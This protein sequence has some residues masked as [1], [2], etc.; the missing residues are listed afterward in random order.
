MNYAGIFNAAISLDGAGS[1]SPSDAHVDSFT[2]KPFIAKAQGH[3]PEGAFVV[4]DPNLIFNGEYKRAGSDLVL[5]H[6]GHEF[7]VP[8]Y[9]R[10]DK[11][12]ALSSPDGAHLSGDIVNA[13]TGHVQYA[14][15]ASGIAAA[16]V[17]GHVTKLSGSATAVRNGVSIILNNGDNVEKGDV[18]STGGDSTLGITFIDGTVFGL[19]SNARMVLNEMVYDPNGS[20]NSSLLSLV[21]GTITFVAGETAKHGDMKIDT[22]V[23][24]MGIRGTAVLSQIHFV[25][26]AGGG[27]PQPEASFQVLVEPNGTT[28]SYILF[29]KVTLLP[30]ATVNQAGQMI[31]ISGGNVSISNALMSPDVQK[32]ITDVFTLKFTDNNTNTKLTTNFTDSIT[33]TSYDILLKTP[34]GA[35]AIATFA[36]LNPQGPQ[37]PG[38][39]TSTSNRIPGPPDARTLDLNGNVTSE[40]ALTERANTTGDTTHSD[41]ISGLITF[42]DQNLGDRPTVSVS[43]G[44]AP[45]YVYKDAGLHDVTGSLTSLQKQDIAATLIN[46]DVVAKGGNTNT[47]SAV[48]TYTIPDHVFDFLAAGETLTL[49]YTVRIANNFTVSPDTA[50]RTITITITGTNDKPVITSSV[51][52]ITFEGGTSVAGGPLTSEVPTSGTLTFKDVDLT[53]THTVAVK[54]TS[55]TLPDGTVPPGPLALF[56]SAMSAAIAAGADSKGSG[57]GTINWSLAALPV[58]LADFIPKNEVLTLVYTVTLTDAQGATSQQTITITIT[59]TDAAAVVW[60]ATDKAGA[61]SGG[62]WKDAANW[63]TGTVPTIDDDVIVIT[64]Q[65]HGLTPSYPVTIDTAAYAKSITMNDFGGPPPEVINKS[66]LTISGALNMSADSIFTNSAAGVMSVGGK[67]E[68]LGASVLTNAGYLTLAGG[69]DFAKGTTITNSGMIE[70]SGGTLKTLALIHNAGG[71]LKADAGTT[72]IVDTAT[73]DGGTV[74]ILGTLELDGTSLIENGALNSSGAVNVKGTVEFAHETVSNSSSGTVKVLANGWL[75]ID[76]GSSVTNTGNVTVDASGK[77]IVNGATISGAGTVTNDGELD[78]NGNAILSGGV[79][80]N[81]AIFNVTGTGNALDGETVTNAGTIEVLA[82][83]VLAI[84][85]GSTVNNSSGSVIVGAT[86]ALTLDNA[87]ISGGAINGGGT[88]HL[89]GASKIDGGATLSVS[90]VTA[91]AKLTLDGVTVS[92]STITDNSSIE[93]DNTVKLKD[94]AKIQGGAITNNGTLEIAGAATLLNDVLT[95]TGHILKIGDNQTLALSGTEI[96]GGTLTVAGT[97]ASSGNT[98]ITDANISNGYLLESTLGGLLTLVATTPA[99]AITNSGIIQANGAKLDIDHEAVA[100]TGTLAAINAGTLK[101]ISATVTNTGSGAVSVESGSMLDLVGAII[102]GGTVTI[103]GTLESTGASAINDADITNTGIITVTGGA[104]TI[105]PGL[106]HAIIN[107][108]LIAAVTGGTLKLTTATITNTGA[109]ITVDGTSKLYLTDVS[110][111]GGSLSNAGNLYSVGLN[112]ITGSVTN[113]GTIEVQGGTLNLSGGL[114]GVGSLIIDDTATLEL[115]GA[116]A[117]TVTFA[118]GTDT[119]QLDNVA[120]QSFTGTIAG[121]STKGG[122]FTITGAADIASASGDALDFTASGGASATPA[123]IVLTPTGALTGAANGIVVTQN[124]AGAISLTATKDI[125]GLNGNGITLRDS[126]TGVGGITVNSLTGKAT[127]TGA[128]SVGVLVENLNAANNG[129]ISITQLGGAVG[130]AYGIDAHTEG[131]G[132]ISI[133]IGGAITGSSTYGI[134]SRSY[135]AGDQTVTTEAGSVVTSGSSGIV[136]VNRA[137]SLGAASDSTIT[138]NAYGT[139][140]SGSSP[141][142]SGNSPGGIEAGYTGATNGT[143]ANTAVNG[144]VVV[145]NHANVTAAAGY[146]INAYNYGNGD[147]TVNSFAGTTISVFGSQSMGINASALSGGTGDITVT[148]GA[149]VT[150]SGATSYGIRAFSIDAGDISVIL[151]NGDKITSGS[152]GIVAVNYAAAIADNVDSTISVKAHGTIHSGSTLNSDGTTPGGIIAGYKPG[153]NST[154]SS[155]VKGDVSVD[156]DATIT[157]DAGYGIE[158][159]TW[160]DGNV[161]VTTGALSSITAAGTAI[162]AFNN[163]GG[164]V[165]VTNEGSATGTVGLAAVALGTGDITI[166]NDGSIT[167]TSLAGISVTQNGAGATGSTHITNT[168]SIVAPTAHAAIYIQENTTGSALIENS[169]TIGPDASTVTSTTYA[170][171]ETGGAIEINNTGHI[172]GNISVATATFNNESSGTWT[173]AGTSVFGNLSSIVN[174]GVIDLHGGSI[175]GTLLSITNSHEIDSWGTASI[176]GTIANTGTIEVHNGALTLFGCLSGTGSVTVDAGALLEVK[177]AVSQTITLAGDGA[178]LQIDTSIFG[179]TIAGLSANDKIDL[180]SIV[181]DDGTSATYNATTGKLVVS[182]AYHHTITLQLTGADYSGAHFAGSSDGHGGTLIT[183]NAADDAPPAFTAAGATLTAT[184]PE[185][186][187]TTGSS[188][189][190]PASGGTGSIVFKDIDL[191]DRPTATITGPLVTALD[192]TTAMT[193]TPDQ[194]TALEHALTLQQAGN[195]NNGTVAWNYSIADKALDFLGAGQTAQVVSTITLDDGHKT[196]TTQV[197]VTIA[198]ANDAPALNVDQA[199]VTQVGDQVTVHGLSVADPDTN[200]TFTIAATAASGAAVNPS[201]GGGSLAIV[202]SALQAVTYTEASSGGPATDMVTVTVTD[203]HNASDTV[204]LIFNLTEAGPVALTGTT[205]KDVFFGTGYQ[206]QFVFATNSNHDTIVNFTSGTNHIDLSFVGVSNVSDWMAHHVAASGADTLITIDA[207]DTILVKGV[208]LQTNDFILHVT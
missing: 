144:T 197:T 69:G 165:S 173:V 200:D 138:I 17:I 137:I 168:G 100:N 114:N 117:Q 71:T 153:G 181:Y 154:Y 30:I 20:N 109:S 203:A 86:A 145:N 57:T 201:T 31:Q 208:S 73:I 11:R 89:T 78:L 64:D 68:I 87:T 51:P 46:I 169:G 14:Q 120:G 39:S 85:H 174:D 50:T 107:H 141:N 131:G 178:E 162:G 196:D 112:T 161:T 183:F 7:I 26:P 139:I 204:N 84:D 108:G 124:G 155:A 6:D 126:A 116:N 13:L 121:Q 4:P 67:A 21:A 118:G 134:R 74:A 83:G 136:A 52:T 157:A 27:E 206:D 179:G 140:N 60:I 35:T 171:V 150:I 97:L 25:V 130:G 99:A 93:L 55:A 12:A 8:D 53:D 190:D 104:L 148:L 96:T 115:S 202:N 43:L 176:S 143:G 90:A 127:G 158:A 18:V 175:S 160:A 41:T 56:Q 82:N 92:G 186:Q 77:L 185:L 40:F 19:S 188:A 142:L 102:D 184:V 159:F 63:E 70:L 76:Q 36:N 79:L 72:L 129:N 3:V 91:D 111:N 110:I 28:G 49:T 65:L 29:D 194:I 172:N 119:L 98:R 32:L 132:D 156:S 105:D 88:I 33:Q 16:Q 146:G 147:V 135:G 151:A 207:A 15:A 193:L 163:G 123:N 177:D 106:A 66:L 166:V 80:N 22:P 58:Y 45:N 198:G 192:H 48:W 205:D 37:G 23:A 94:A 81:N 125:S 101:L 24:T 187:N 189:L 2:G 170:I 10:G 195:T 103:A 44:D 164:D 54:L 38:T 133:D 113:I 34:I 5:S 9:F 199:S 47:G 167:S 152:A 59:G 182:D 180:S 75:T 95:N 62:F 149:N 191:T 42:L 61:P 1:H 128:N 122:T